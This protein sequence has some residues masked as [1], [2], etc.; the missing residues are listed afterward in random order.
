[1]MGNLYCSLSGTRVIQIKTIPQP[2]QGMQ[3]LT[4]PVSLPT[5]LG[6]KYNTTS[7]DDRGWCLFEQGAA[8]IAASVGK[9]DEK[10][11]DISTGE[12]V[13]H[14][15]RRAPP[16]LAELERQVNKAKFSGKGD[17]EQVMQLLKTFKTV[18]HAHQSTH[19]KAAA[20][21]TAVRVLAQADVE[22]GPSLTLARHQSHSGT[23]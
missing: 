16:S 23:L 22:L 7:Y 21:T 14:D 11:A 15:T 2:P 19:K 18:L 6:A 3:D 8:T 10:L 13:Y 4:G 12:A 17:K 5:A 9:R 1:M 20:A